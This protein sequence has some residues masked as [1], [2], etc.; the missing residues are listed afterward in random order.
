MFKSSKAVV[1]I[2]VLIDNHA[3]IQT[4]IEVTYCL[5]GFKNLDVEP[6]C[7]LM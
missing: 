3:L 2:C 1:K 4:R 7:W 5:M 6:I